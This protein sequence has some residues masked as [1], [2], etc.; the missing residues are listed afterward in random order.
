[1][2][3][4]LTNTYADYGKSAPMLFGEEGKRFIS[5]AN[6]PR[7]ASQDE[8]NRLLEVGRLVKWYK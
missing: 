6:H 2:A 4:T 7:Q 8:I 5:R 3:V 1:M